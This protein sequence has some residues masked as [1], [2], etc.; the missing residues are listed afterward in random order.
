MADGEEGGGSLF[1]AKMDGWR[2]EYSEGI[3]G[4]EEKGLIGSPETV[5]LHIV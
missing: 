1:S 2:K 3:S 4:A 5:F